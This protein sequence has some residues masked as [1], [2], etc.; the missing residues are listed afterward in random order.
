MSKNKKENSIQQKFCVE[1]NTT[2]KTINKTN[3][4]SIPIKKVKELNIKP[5]DAVFVKIFKMYVGENKSD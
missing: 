5:G 1:F 4:I 3:Y 2:V